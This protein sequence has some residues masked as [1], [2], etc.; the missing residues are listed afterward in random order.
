MRGMNAPT[1]DQEAM[2]APV[3]RPVKSRW[4]YRHRWLALFVGLPTI[5]GI[6]YYGLIASDIYVSQSRFVI[7]SPGQKGMQTTT[8]ASLIQTTGFSSG[9]D[10]TQEVLE[11]VRSR[12][13]LRD[14]DRRIDVRARYSAQNV[15]FLSRFPT[16]FRDASFENLFRYYRSMVLADIDAESGMAV[17]EVRAFR[18]DD[19]YLINARLLDL[20]EGLV[21]RLNNRAE[22]RAI[23]EAERRVERAQNR[24][25]DARL[26]LGSFRDRERIID[27]TKQAAAVLEISSE[28][29]AEQAALMSQLSLMTRST[30]R[31]PAIPALRSRI[32]AIGQQIAAQNNRAVGGSNDI[33][34][35]LGRYQQLELEQEFSTQALTAASASLEQA[36]TESQK[37]QFYLERVVEPNRPD[38]PLLPNRLKAILVIFAAS[39]CLYFIG[40]MLVVGILEHSPED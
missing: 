12:D 32:A 40:W 24:F 29:V 37:Q 7:K 38:L 4:Y 13:A 5:L 8:L 20:S 34:S 9:K 33:A 27:P 18:P 25:R 2:R 11:Y 17:L 6:L 21:N 19:A 16:P 39:L 26:Q 10:Q 23:A 14:L 35:T 28:L 1:I 22:I 15:D 31:H 3:R 30:P 36:R